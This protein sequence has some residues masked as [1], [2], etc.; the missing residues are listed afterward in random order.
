MFVMYSEN[1]K[2]TLRQL[3]RLIVFDLFG[4]ISLVV[5]YVITSNTGYDGI[6]ALCFGIVL[7]IAYLLILIF[8]MKYIRGSYL[9]FMKQ[10]IGTTLTF[11][12]CVL[13]LVKFFAS[14]VMVTR[15]FTEVISQTLLDRYSAIVIIIPMIIVAG[16][17]GIKGCEVRARFSEVLYFI[18]LVPIFLLLL[19]GLRNVDIANLMPMFTANITKT[20]YGAYGYFLIFNVLELLLF[21]KHFV[22]KDQ[23]ERSV[24]AA[25]LSY[26]LQALIIVFVFSGLFFVMTTGIV[27][28]TAA[29][30]KIWSSVMVMQLIKIPWTLLNRQDSLVLALWMISMFSILGAFLYYMCTIMK[31]M[32]RIRNKKY[33]MPLLVVIIVL[34]SAVPMDLEQYYEY[35]VRYITYIGLPQTFILP[36]LIILVDRIRSAAGNDNERSK[37]SKKTVQAAKKAAKPLSMLLAGFFVL[38]MLTSCGN[39]VQIEDREFVQALAVDYVNNELTAYY[40][41]PDLAAISNQESTDP[42]K[43]LRT[44]HGGDFYDIEEQ[45]KLCSAKKLDYSHLKVLILGEKM[46]QNEEVL[47][48]FLDYVQNNY[49][50]S[51]NTYIF[52]VKEDVKNIVDYNKNVENGIGEYLDRLY[53]NNLVDSEKEEITLG[54]LINA[55][56]N[57]DLAIQLPLL[58]ILNNDLAIDGVGIVKNS[59][60]V[61][62]VEGQD[63]VYT[64]L[65]SGF[66]ENSRIFV[67]DEGKE[68]PT[69]VVRLSDIMNN[70]S[71][72]IRNGKPFYSFYVQATGVVEK[73]LDA[74]SNLATDEKQKVT[75]TIK[76]LVDEKLKSELSKQFETIEKQQRI[77]YL[78]IYRLCRYKN[79][80]LFRFYEGNQSGFIDALQFDIQV[81]VQFY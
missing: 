36:I 74:Y 24:L 70:K 10:T 40:I 51:K 31:G 66:G 63:T 38:G 57:D 60:L 69:Y 1:K 61:Y 14:V 53:K 17:L 81:D 3:K 6:P 80:K 35:Y 39:R 79:P 28:A 41:L 32:F 19:L 71:I 67:P 62:E 15:L 33:L 7:V 27:G 68:D 43:L 55:K 26:S 76:K 34:G 72:T 58:T 77:D 16:Y 9:D 75:K 12:V 2:I 78:N 25:I 4:I 56:N 64:D 13:Y 65:L 30:D 8:F 73:G 21:V 23:K 48:E 18:V 37:P 5:P 29:S 44:F 42:E 54:S 50:I 46:M 20:V 45:Y 59:R 47:T 11:V 22:A 52:L 49:E